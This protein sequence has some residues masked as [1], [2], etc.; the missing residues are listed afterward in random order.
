MNSLGVVLS[1]GGLAGA[2]LSSRRDGGWPAAPLTE[3]DLRAA[4]L[5]T[6]PLPE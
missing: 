6:I 4:H 5:A 1:P 3:P 2:A